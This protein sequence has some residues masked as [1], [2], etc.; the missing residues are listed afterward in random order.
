MKA[1]MIMGVEAGWKQWEWVIA[2]LLGGPRSVL[3]CSCHVVYVHGPFLV[4]LG[5][6]HRTVTVTAKVTVTWK[7]TVNRALL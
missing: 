6:Q 7:L 4:G 1:R 5:G 3:K 2:G